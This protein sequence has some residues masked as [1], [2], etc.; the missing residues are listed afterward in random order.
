VKIARKNH[1][2]DLSINEQP[3][4]LSAVDQAQWFIEQ[5]WGGAPIVCQYP[6]ETHISVCVGWTPRR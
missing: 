3:R 4:G 6:R 2:I 1:E 5:L